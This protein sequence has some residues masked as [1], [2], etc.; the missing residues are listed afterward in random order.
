MSVYFKI[1]SEFINCIYKIRNIFYLTKSI[2][3][4]FKYI[5][6]H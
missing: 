1:K 2:K 3:E 6:C 4:V 5:M